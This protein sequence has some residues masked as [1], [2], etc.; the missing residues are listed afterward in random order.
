MFFFGKLYFTSFQS[1]MSYFLLHFMSLIKVVFC[2][3]FNTWEQCKWSAF[4]GMDPLQTPRE[5]DEYFAQSLWP[6]L[7]PSPCDVFNLQVEET[8]CS[9]WRQSTAW[10]VLQPGI[11]PHHV[12]LSGQRK[13]DLAWF[14]PMFFLW[15]YC[16]LDCTDTIGWK[17]NWAVWRHSWIN[18][19]LTL[20]LTELTIVLFF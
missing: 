3:I 8:G 11:E 13:T 9:E 18:N 12:D 15:Q 1:I 5:P 2:F 19:E 14:L 20:S 16:G 10:H 17:L 4:I 6:S 7:T